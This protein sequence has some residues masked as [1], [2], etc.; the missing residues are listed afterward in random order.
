[1]RFRRH[2]ICTEG[3]TCSV[4]EGLVLSEIL[5]Q[6]TAE[7]T[8]TEDRIHQLNGRRIGMAR[9]KGHWLRDADGAL[10]RTFDAR[11]PHLISDR[12]SG[13]RQTFER[14]SARFHLPKCVLAFA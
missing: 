11:K 6:S 1:M 3:T 12:E 5:H 9:W 13:G 8:S 4:C 7:G 2:R 14:M 10:H